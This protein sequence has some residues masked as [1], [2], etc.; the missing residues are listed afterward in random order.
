MGFREIRRSERITDEDE[1]RR[2]EN[3]NWCKIK[4]ESIMT[5]EEMSLAFQAIFGQAIAEANAAISQER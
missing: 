3:E 2:R 5:D 1:R 4:P